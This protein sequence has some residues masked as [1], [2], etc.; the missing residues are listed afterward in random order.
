MGR[1]GFNTIKN[2]IALMTIIFFSCCSED[3]EPWAKNEMIAEIIHV[4][5]NP[6]INFKATGSDVQLGC[7]TIQTGTGI[8]GIDVE[9]NIAIYFSFY[10]C[11]KSTGKY[12]VQTRYE[13]PIYG[14]SSLEGGQGDSITITKLDDK[15]IEGFFDVV[16]YCNYPDN[17]C[18]V[19]DSIIIRGTFKGQNF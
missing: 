19:N 11:A 16:L 17:Y 8:S 3:E 7:G 15:Y 13:R 5:P 4:N 14:G 2:V 18:N 9:N 10:P 1:S 6:V 12:S